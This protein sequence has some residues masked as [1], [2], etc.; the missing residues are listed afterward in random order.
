MRLNWFTASEKELP[1]GFVRLIVNPRK[2]WKP[3]PN[4]FVW[5]SRIRV[6]NYLEHKN[7]PVVDVEGGPLAIETDFGRFEIHIEAE[8]ASII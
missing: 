8:L 7:F 6:F 4:M 5:P 1:N 2:I 3:S